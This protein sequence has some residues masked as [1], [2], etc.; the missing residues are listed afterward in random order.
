M[1]FPKSVCGD[2]SPCHL[3]TAAQLYAFTVSATRGVQARFPTGNGCYAPCLLDDRKP[4]LQY[5]SRTSFTK[6]DYQSFSIRSLPSQGSIPRRLNRNKSTRRKAYFTLQSNISRPKGISQ[7]L[8]GFISLKKAP[9][10]S[11]LFSG[12]PT[13]NRTPVFAVR[14]RKRAF[15][16]F[17]IIDNKI[18]ANG[19]VKPLVDKL[20]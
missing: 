3:S 6:N 2:K 7:I 12:D 17:L 11:M 4:C 14:G 18:P 8:Q 15:L 19:F 1:R 20:Y 13:G 10:K 5:P 9:T 16:L